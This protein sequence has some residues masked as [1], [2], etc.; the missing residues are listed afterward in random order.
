MLSLNYLKALVKRSILPHPEPSTLK[1][2][3]A[4]PIV[5]AGMFRTSNGIGR[6]ARCCYDALLR[7][8]L[9]PIAVDISEL[10]NQANVAPSVALTAFPL[11]KQGTLILFANPPE[12][13]RCLMGLGLRRWHQWRIIGAWA[14]ETPIV[15][16]AWMM[17]AVHVSE[18]WAPSQFCADAFSAVFEKPV[19]TVPHFVEVVDDAAAIPGSQSGPQLG[20]RPSDRPLRILTMADARSSL[21][22]KNLVA[23]VEMFL[24]ALPGAPGMHLTLKCRDLDLYPDYAA[25]LAAAVGGERRI[26]IINETLTDAEQERLFKESDIILSPHR[27]EGFGLHLAEAM[28]RGKCVIATGWS[29][30]LEFMDAQ[31]SVLIP[32]SLVPVADSTGVYSSV[33]GAVWAD[34]DTRAAAQA[35]IELY[36]D[37]AQLTALGKSA[38]EKISGTLKAANYRRA[39]EAT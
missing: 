32:Y 21:E 26:S 4:A 16:E 25:A 13:E 15:P 8:G 9:C 27:S 18:I 31:C 17:Q 5:V 22:R 24:A 33:H 30:N 39:L 7:E 6:A 14:W 34:P 29:G 12:I 36:Q 1:R 2:S 37:Q 35:L 10:L 19:R 11:A 20:D 23:A 28:A 3:I 38:Q